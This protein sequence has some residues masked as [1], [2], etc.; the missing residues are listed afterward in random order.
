[1][2]VYTRLVSHESCRRTVFFPHLFTYVT[3][4]M[5]LWLFFL[6]NTAT[7]HLTKS[8]RLTFLSQPHP[9]QA[10]F[11]SFPPSLLAC[12]SGQG[13]DGVC[14]ELERGRGL[15]VR[16]RLNSCTWLSPARSGERDYSFSQAVQM[17]PLSTAIKI[18][19][20]MPTCIIPSPCF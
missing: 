10:P 16:R 9:S 4:E 11:S 20:L 6:Q 13:G 15:R 12:A 18:N 14:G 5:A 17:Q 19:I 3:Y 8:I 1:M 2:C 7:W